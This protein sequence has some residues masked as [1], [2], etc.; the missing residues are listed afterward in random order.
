MESAQVTNTQNNGISR[1]GISQILLGLVTIILAGI[2]SWLSIFVIAFILLIWAV[3]EGYQAFK[4]R[5]YKEFTLRVV[6][7]LLSFT[8]GMLLL[9]QPTLGAAI[10]SLLLAFLFIAGGLYK[11]IIAAYEKIPRWRWTVI[12]GVVSLILGLLIIRLWPIS[13]FWLLGVLLGIEILINGWTLAI[14]SGTLKQTS[15]RIGGAASAH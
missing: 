1:I 9:I 10:L 12:G 8:I 2:T 11:I 3:L 4:M 7:A 6:T 5:G 14:V 15:S 13:R